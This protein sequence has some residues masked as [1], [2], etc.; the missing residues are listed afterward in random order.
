MNLINGITNLLTC[1][2]WEYPNENELFHYVISGESLDTLNIEISKGTYEITDIEVY[3]LDYDLINDINDITPF[4]IKNIS[5]KG[6]KGDIKVSSDGYF[7][8]TIPYDE[9]FTIKVNNKLVKPEIVNKAFLGFKLEKGDYQINIYYKAPL[10]EVGKIITMLSS[11]IFCAL[12]IT[13]IK[14]H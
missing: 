14:K 7:I 2:T 6:L 10:F 8:T 4:N 1:E 13:E 11:I 5:D 9:G 3:M 12:I